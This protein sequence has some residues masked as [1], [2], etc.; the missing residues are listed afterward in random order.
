MFINGRNAVIEALRAGG[1]VEKVYLMYGVEGEPVRRIRR[2]A[3]QAGV[4]CVMIDKA[5]FLAMEREH[6]LASR[7]Q[8]VIALM[9]EI[10]YVDLEVLIDSQLQE[11]RS[12]VVVAMDGITDPHNVGA[13]IRSAECAGIDGVLL[14]MRDSGSI[15]DTVTKASAGAVLHVPIAR[16]ANVIDVL[17]GLQQ[18]GMSLVGLDENGTMDYTE[19]DYS[20][21]TVIVVGSEGKGLQPRIRK[22]CDQVVSIPMRGQIASLNAS[23][24]AGVVLF[25]SVRQRSAS[26]AAA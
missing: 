24:A 26:D 6:D 25:E 13:I 14:G 12:P 19:Y 7:S 21:P 8:G 3:K 9:S 15:T 10:E 1:R 23:V 18:M 4:P 11:G 16:V 2:E 5:R 17:I 22:M 20:K